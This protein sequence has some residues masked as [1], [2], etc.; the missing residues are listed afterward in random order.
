[1]GAPITVIVNGRAGL[2]RGPAKT[3]DIAALFR[4]VGAEARVL[5][6]RSGS[7]LRSLAEQ[8]ARERPPVIVACGGDGTMNTIASVLAET[9]I[10]L[11]V[12]PLGTLNHFARD[13]GIPLDP[14]AAARTIVEG[15]TAQVD[16]GEVNGRIFVNNSSLG[17]YPKIVRSRE[18]WRKRLGLGKWTALAW[19][20]LTVLRRSPFVSVRLRL[21]DGEHEYR[22]PFVFV[23][24]NEYIMEGFGIGR[25]E[26][27]DG[28]QL[29]LYVTHRRGRWALIGL[30]LRALF[31]RLHQAEDFDAR[32]VQGIDIESRRKWLRVAMD[33]E[34]TTMATPLHYRIR[35]GGLRVI[36]P[37][38]QAGALAQAA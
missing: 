28:G 10:V 5:R 38:P 34:V 13:L 30:A 15:H 21:D 33:G 27:L 37:A 16:L 4:A 8:A 7:E 18:N 2:G 11:G 22:A 1:V 23:G 20:T 32:I 9:D 26:R 36:V 29:S 14:Q 12:L 6:A 17:L 24:N 19:A 25:R 35:P 3:D 31:G